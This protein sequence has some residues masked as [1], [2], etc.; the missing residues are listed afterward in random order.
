MQSSIF[1]TLLINM[2]NKFSLVFINCYVI[3]FVVNTGTVL[4]DTK[5]CYHCYAT[6]IHQYNVR[7][8]V[9]ATKNSIRVLRWQ[10]IRFLHCWLKRKK[11]IHNNSQKIFNF[12]ST[13]LLLLPSK[14]KRKLFLL[15]QRNTFHLWYTAQNTVLLTFICS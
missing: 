9:G 10:S 6:K 4:T 2:I 12:F 14:R 1:Y 13:N 5:L 8:N 3:D 15:L 11:P 7:Y